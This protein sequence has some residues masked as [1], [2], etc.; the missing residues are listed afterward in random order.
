MTAPT[1]QARPQA[2]RKHLLLVGAGHAHLHV[3]QMLAQHR[4]AHLDVTLLTPDAWQT[5]SGMVPGYVAGRY[6]LD[7]CRIALQPLLRAAGVSWIPGLC[8]GI[9]AAQSQVT[10]QPTDSS[11][12]MP[13]TLRYD[14]LSLDTGAVF[15]PLRLAADMPGALEHTLPVRPI[16]DFI[17]RWQTMVEQRQPGRTPHYQQPPQTA[18]THTANATTT[19]WAFIGAGAASVE[20]L[21]AAHQRLAAAPQAAGACSSASRIQLVLVTGGGEVAAGYAPGIQRRVLR[22]LA[23]RQVQVV[24]QRCVGAQPGALRLEDGSLL[25]CDGAVLAVGTHAP[26]WL[27]GSGLALADTGHLRVN[28][29]QQSTSHANVFAAGDVATRAD[30]AHPK[31]GV[32]A[33]RAGP[34]LAH[35]LL[36]AAHSQPLKPHHPPTRTLNLLSCGTHHAILSWGPLHAEGAWAWWLKDR[37][38]RAFV[39]RYASEA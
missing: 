33:V 17:E 8:T 38:D 1:P 5:Y 3:L 14:L 2:P 19:T 35:N 6:A 13:Q 31:S 15:D 34:P 24:R 9:D 29:F 36:A 25:P 23:K 20:L 7:A 11:Q 21:M 12:K 4:P 37:I 10:L 39:A 16:D 30:A 27:Q 28:P 18:H 22:Q 32:Y 26:R